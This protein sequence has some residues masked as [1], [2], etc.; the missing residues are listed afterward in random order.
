ME[1]QEKPA[2]PY[3]KRAPYVPPT[4]VVLGEVRDLTLSG[5][6]SHPDGKASRGS[7]MM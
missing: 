6:T 5:G 4:M 3:A 1:S 7:K 2:E